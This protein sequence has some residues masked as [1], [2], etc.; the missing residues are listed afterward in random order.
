M[1]PGGMAGNV[2]VAFTR[3]GGCAR[4]LGR[5]AR[6]DDG[7]FLRGDL[8]R[9]GVD[10]SLAGWRD[11]GQTGRSLILVGARGERA[12]VGSWRQLAEV[13][14]LAGRLDGARIE[15]VAEMPL[16]V[17]RRSLTTPW[18]PPTGAFEPPAAALYCPATFA[19]SVLTALPSDF[20]LFIDIEAGHLDGLS[21]AEVDGLLRRTEL[22][23]GNQRVLA[24]LA[25]RLGL[26]RPEEIGRRVGGTLVATLGARGA[27]VVQGE[28]VRRVPGRRVAVVDTTGAGDC[29]AAAYILAHL[30]GVAPVVAASFANAAAALSTRALGARTRAPTADE[31]ARYLAEQQGGAGV[32]P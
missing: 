15:E 6:D 2:V 31:L 1:A 13:S 11:G 27:L 7:V 32:A 30:R 22:V 8:Q 17:W 14:R 10:I 12:I 20:S 23:F 29:F 25:A 16:P 9:E 5:F 4:F 24:S 21:V 19:P 3:L 18:R 28:D 26:A